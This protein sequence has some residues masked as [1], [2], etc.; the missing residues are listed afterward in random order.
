MAA[1]MQDDEQRHQQKAKEKRDE[2]SL[3]GNYR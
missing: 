1:F 3:C 2:D